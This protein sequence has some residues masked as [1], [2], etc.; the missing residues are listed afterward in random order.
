MRRTSRPRIG[1]GIGAT[2]LAIA[3]ACAAVF[4][5]EVGAQE[6]TDYQASASPMSWGGTDYA[7]PFPGETDP[8][9]LWLLPGSAEPVTVTNDGQ[10]VPGIGGNAPVH[11]AL[12]D[13]SGSKL[14][15]YASDVVFDGY[16]GP[17]GRDCAG[18]ELLV[19]AMTGGTVTPTCENFGVKVL[20]PTTPGGPYDFAGFA[21]FSQPGPVAVVPGWTQP[22]WLRPGGSDDDPPPAPGPYSTTNSPLVRDGV[23]FATLPIGDESDGGP[24]PGTGGTIWL[25]QA[26][27]EEPSFVL[28][29]GTFLPGIPGPFGLRPFHVALMT[30]DGYHMTVYLDDAVLTE[31]PGGPFARSCAGLTAWLDALE[32]GP[33]SYLCRDFKAE[34][35]VPDGE[36][37]DFVFTGLGGFE[38]GASVRVAAGFTAPP[39]LVY[40]DYSGPDPAPA[41][42]PTGDPAPAPAGTSGS[43][44]DAGAAGAGPVPTL[45]ATGAPTW[46]LALAG[47]VLLGAGTVLV[48]SS[49]VEPGSPGA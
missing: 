13:V 30:I 28:R 17:Y 32:E 3:L 45:P 43:G 25:T 26:F 19:P 47:T 14:T 8:G 7:D 44:S 23:T 16:G 18:L 22:P 29:D 21:V 35:F 6:V 10:D 4:A 2:T 15:V 27:A 40:G 12:V 24:P 49:A 41:D 48:R 42:A 33:D 31:F 20:T 1:A 37:R 39:A 38:S 36:G 11:V 46:I 5:P 9:T 34:I